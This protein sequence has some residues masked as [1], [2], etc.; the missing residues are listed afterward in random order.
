[1]DKVNLFFFILIFILKF[2]FN[3]FV[4]KTKYIRIIYMSQ[5]KSKKNLINPYRLLGVSF[6]ST[7][8]ELKKAYYQLALLCHPDRGGNSEDMKVVHKAYKYIK[9]QMLNAN[10][11]LESYGTYM[12]HRSLKGAP[13]ESSEN[14][15]KGQISLRVRKDIITYED[16]EEEFQKFCKEQEIKPP[17]FPAIFEETNDFVRKFNEEF[18]SNENII[19]NKYNPFKKGYDSLME[20]TNIEETDYQKLSNP[21]DPSECTIQN[22]FTNQVIIYEEPQSL[23]NTYGSFLRYDTENIDDFTENNGKISMTDYLKAYA[24]LEE[25]K[26]FEEEKDVNKLYEERLKDYRIQIDE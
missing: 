20:Q 22:K 2:L 8:P 7:V 26:P 12:S 18:E 24:P 13:T 6:N 4:H 1:L 10:Y 19:N 9:E 5:I 3:K 15:T 23:P 25:M 17:P 21:S 16:L 11:P 14:L